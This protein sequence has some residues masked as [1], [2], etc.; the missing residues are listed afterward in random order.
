VAAPIVPV[1]KG[2]GPGARCLVFKVVDLKTTLRIPL[3]VVAEASTITA[4][5]QH[6][7]ELLGGKSKFDAGMYNA[8][9]KKYNIAK[10]GDKPLHFLIPLLNGKPW[11]PTDGGIVSDTAGHYV[12][13]HIC[14]LR[15]F[16]G[17]SKGGEHTF[18]LAD[19]PTNDKL[20][21][22]LG[23][24]PVV[25]KLL[26]GG[27][28]GGTPVVGKLS[29]GGGGGAPVVEVPKLGGGGGAPKCV[30]RECPEAGK[31]V[32]E[33]PGCDNNFCGDCTAGKNIQ[34]VECKR[35]HCGSCVQGIFLEGFFKCDGSDVS[36]AS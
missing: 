3:E 7:Y 35:V 1:I 5:Y 26:G 17:V 30:E 9:N 27:G 28:G 8:A 22:M 33:T 15:N 23:G 18:Y 32:C 14:D 16:V 36:P 2:D 29:G 31:F 24:A 20:R 21:E 12:L 11:P 34:C 6:I 25:R 19:A 4:G 13:M 10:K